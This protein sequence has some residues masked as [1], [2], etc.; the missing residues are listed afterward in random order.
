MSEFIIKLCFLLLSGLM[1]VMGVISCAGEELAKT[2]LFV[3]L[4]IWN[5]LVALLARED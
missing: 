1:M 3:G 4:G 2:V 5:V